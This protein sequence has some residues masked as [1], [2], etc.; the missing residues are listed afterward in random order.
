MNASAKNV[1]WLVTGV[2]V[3][4]LLAGGVVI[5][6]AEEEFAG[7]KLTTLGLGLN[8][9]EP[10]SATKIEW[11]QSQN[12]EGTNSG[13]ARWLAARVVQSESAFTMAGV[14]VDTKTI[15][16]ANDY[17]VSSARADQNGASLVCYEDGYTPSVAT[18]SEVRAQFDGDV[19][20]TLGN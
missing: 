1:V 19:V 4:L 12:I 3:G 13:D 16:D 5:A 7:V 17:D 6:A 9:Q 20:I 14:H 15:G 8:N 10:S 2:C 11:P 18:V